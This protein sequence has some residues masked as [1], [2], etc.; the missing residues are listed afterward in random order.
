VESTTSLD[1]EVIISSYKALN[2]MEEPPLSAAS[3]TRWIPGQKDTIGFSRLILPDTSMAVSNVVQS[4]A[5]MKE[6]HE[7][8]TV[9]AAKELG[10]ITA[11]RKRLVMYPEQVAGSCGTTVICHDQSLMAR[12]VV[13][14]PILGSLG[15][16]PRHSGLI[17]IRHIDVKH[18]LLE[19]IDNADALMTESGEAGVKPHMKKVDSWAVVAGRAPRRAWW[20]AIDACLPH[21]T[22]G[23]GRDCRLPAAGPFAQSS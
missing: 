8:L 4:L 19:P 9:F 6:V 13:A 3:A 23:S 22:C 2:G 14:I 20:H 10:G 18:G 5:P 11:V 15:Q 16:P 12:M 7:W 1:C 17:S 21:R